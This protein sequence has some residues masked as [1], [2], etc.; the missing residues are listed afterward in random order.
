MVHYN[1]LIKEEV[2]E[3]KEKTKK[4]SLDY[5]RL[6]R[7]AVLCIGGIKKLIKPTVSDSTDIKYYVSN[8]ELFDIIYEAHIN[9][10]HGGRN[11]LEK[12]LNAK[13]ANVCREIILIFL[14]LCV[15]CQKKKNHP[16]KGLVVKP[17]LFK[18]INVRAQV[19]LIDMQTCKDGDFKFILNYQDHLTKFI[20]LYP[21]KTKTAEEVAH[22][23][24]NIFCTLGT[25]SVLQSDNGRE[26]VNNIIEALKDMWP[27]LS[28]VHGKPRHSKRRKAHI[29]IQ[30]IPHS[31]KFLL[32]TEEDL[33][34][35]LD[36]KI[37]NIDENS[38]AVDDRQVENSTSSEHLLC[39]VCELETSGAHKCNKCQR[40]VHIICG[41]SGTESEEGFGSQLLCT[42]CFNKI[43]MCTNKEKALEG[44]TVQAE[45]M[46]E[47]SNKK[48]SEIAIGTSAKIPIPSVDRGKGDSRSVIGIVM[49]VS[50]EGYYK[51]GTKHGII[52]SLYSRNQLS[53]CDEKFLNL[54][55]V[56]NKPVSLRHI[57]G[58]E[59]LFGLQGFIKS[60]WALR[61]LSANTWAKYNIKTKFKTLPKA[62]WALRSLPANTWAKYNTKPVFRTLPKSARA[63]CEMT[64]QSANCPHS[65]L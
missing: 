52:R 31:M 48:F 20:M 21:L 33:E 25:P 24:L 59:S 41:V 5:R 22:C 47:I 7:Y 19:D 3:A 30:S 45:E 38:E 54:E 56:P 2:E 17:L 64:G 18:E 53:S 37:D 27:D 29:G 36:N 57:N 51:I 61:S 14:K 11:R 23:L 1:E 10:G 32:R 9:C 58:E 55:E 40:Y 49:E 43:Q 50:A 15:V 8:C 63:N 28:I 13:Y 6:N 42:L 65:G 44:L 46:K 35:I 34:K 39:C 62:A 16:K 12:A 4:S 60:I 26:F